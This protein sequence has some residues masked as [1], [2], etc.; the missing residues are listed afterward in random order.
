MQNVYIS[1]K[2]V[3]TNKNSMIKLGTILTLSVMMFSIAPAFALDLNFTPIS[4]PFNNPIGIDHF[5]PTNEVVLSVNY[6]T[7][8]PFNFETVSLDGTHTQFSTISG[9]TDEVKIAT[10]RDDGIN[11]FVPGTL[12]T[13]NGVDGQIVM[14]N[15]DGTFVNPWVDLPGVG[16]GLMRGSLYV[17]R[18]G[19]YNGDLIIATTTGEVWRIDSAANASMIDD[20]NVHLEGLVTVPDD[21]RYGDMAGK[22]LAGAEDESRV[23]AFDNNGL[24]TSW[25]TPGFSIED[26]DLIPENENFFGVNFGTSRLLGVPAASFAGLEGEILITDETFSGFSGLALLKWDNDASEPVVEI[27]GLEAGSFVPAQWEHVTFSSAG[28]SEIPP[29]EELFCGELESYYNVIDGTES[30]DYLLGT[31]SPDLIFGNGG[32]DL[33]YSTGEDNCI[34]AG[35]GNDFVIAQK[36]GNVVYGGAGDDSILLK[37]TGI[38]YAEDGDDAI[39]IIKPSA[40]HLIDGGNEYDLCTTNTVQT[41]NVANCEL[42][43]P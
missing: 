36:D 41:I 15:P 28:I 2:I 7:G 16:N 17:D 9:F 37:G 6:S 12:F 5:E 11:F 25:I 29:V 19:I 34:Y 38:A 8:Q 23:Y 22:I 13:G 40:G 4:T 32:N 20:V 27:I 10:A 43:N 21:P 14:I 3:N 18:T 39:H 26:I 31:N 30:S 33:I 1:H 42:V 24:V 35:D